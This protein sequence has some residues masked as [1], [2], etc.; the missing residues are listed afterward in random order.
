MYV[1]SNRRETENIFS[2]PLRTRDP[3]MA[4]AG[5]RDGSEERLRFPML[6]AEVMSVSFPARTIVEL[7][8]KHYR[9]LLKTETD[10]AKRRTIAD[11]LAEEEA[12]FA[13]LAHPARDGIER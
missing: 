4:F 6:S 1:S 12:K 8:I 2:L 10:A 13:K 9:D 11:L 7:N 5:E 3:V